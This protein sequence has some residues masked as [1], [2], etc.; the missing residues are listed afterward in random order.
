MKRPI[1]FIVSALL[2]VT[3]VA[4]ETTTNATGSILRTSFDNIPYWR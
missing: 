3:S 4:A 2:A 1:I